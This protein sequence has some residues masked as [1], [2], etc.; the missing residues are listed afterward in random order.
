MVADPLIIDTDGSLSIADFYR[1]ES[2][3]N[4]ACF[5][6]SPLAWTFQWRL[7]YSFY[8]DSYVSMATFYIDQKL[9]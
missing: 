5:D 9:F 7:L 8:I 4:S 2:L 3:S 1:H 6:V